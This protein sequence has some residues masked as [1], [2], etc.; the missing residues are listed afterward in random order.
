[1]SALSEAIAGR[2]PTAGLDAVSP[3]H[4]LRRGSIRTV[5]LVAQSVA[6]VAPAGV[7]L[8]QTSGLVSRA[9]SFA[10]FDLLLTATIVVLVALSMS[11]FARRISAAGGIYTF[12]T[13]GLGPLLGM[14]AGAA[15]ALGYAAI[16][17]D[18]L[19]SGVRRITSLIDPT[20]G[21]GA[22][23]AV[24]VLLGG[25]VITLVIA[26]G[27]RMS[28]RIMLV[29]EAIAVSAILIVSV[30]VFAST[31][32]NLSPLVPDLSHVPPIT[33]FAGGIGIAVVAFVGFES[34]AAL[35]PESRRPLSSVPRALVWTACAL[36]AVYLFGVAAQL[37]AMPAAGQEGTLLA[38]AA[39]LS[40]ASWVEPTI[41]IVIAA[42]WVACTLACTNALVRLVFSMAREGVLPR[43][44]GATS[45]RFASPHIAAVAIGAILTFG[46][47]VRLWG[48]RESL[49]ADV[50][51]IATS[52]GFILAYLLV[53]AAACAYL[54]R[55]REFSFREAWPALVA[56]VALAGVVATEVAGIGSSRVAL[57]VFAA[58]VAG[59]ALAH[60]V[61]CRYGPATVRVGVYDTPVASDALRAD[62][63]WPR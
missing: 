28:T 34:G 62:Q 44:L 41:D 8:A 29:I 16:S 61:R 46:T 53:S 25:A 17:I 56:T 13:R 32:W 35:G 2:P 54:L 49:Y 50:I 23:P 14:V 40:G 63:P 6:A 45:R 38:D 43:L 24:L 1:M 3:L 11:I 33:S 47:L 26:L 57:W 42:S 21:D 39:Y 22:L 36:A 51:G 9:G 27:A 60:V 20:G 7:L 30:A 52:M 31:G 19:R 58:L 37:S 18:T 59:L 4:G 5:D 48:G 15:M 55:L 12:V 10:F